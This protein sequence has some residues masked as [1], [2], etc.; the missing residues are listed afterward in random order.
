MKAKVFMFILVLSLAINAA[1]LAT[2]G[3][4]YYRNTYLIP[5][6]LC[7]I[8]PEDHHLY[9]DLGL[10]NQQLTQMEPLARSFHSRLAELA[11]SMEGK[12][13][14]LVDL[15]SQRDIDPAKIE[16]LRKE[17]AGIQDEIQKEVIDHILA[18]KKILSAAQQQQF[19]NLM[20]K[21]MRGGSYW[22]AKEKP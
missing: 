22:L 10:S 5:S 12:K 14:N 7:P 16:G 17:M 19:F 1:V 15:L 9:Q 6:L 3:Y 20:Q 8:S 18:F 13:E 21:S 4:H 11:A 2:T